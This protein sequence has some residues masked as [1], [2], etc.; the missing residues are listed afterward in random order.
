M[1]S[2]AISVESGQGLALITA[3][4][5]ATWTGM[6]SSGRPAWRGSP[7]QMADPALLTG[8]IALQLAS[9]VGTV[10]SQACR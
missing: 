9:L 7:G 8:S 3:E 6:P 10:P 5:S 1:D 4:P 2:F